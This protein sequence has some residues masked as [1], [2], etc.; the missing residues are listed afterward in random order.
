MKV[1]RTVGLKL[2]PEGVLEGLREREGFWPEKKM[3]I[4]I[5]WLPSVGQVL[6][7]ILANYFPMKKRLGYP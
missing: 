1:E 6:C 7:W 3:E 4:N 5:H 2:Y